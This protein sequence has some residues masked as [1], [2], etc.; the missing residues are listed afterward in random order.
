MTDRVGA[1][2][3]SEPALSARG[4]FA[5]RLRTHRVEIE[6]AAI[7]RICA[8]SRPDPTDHA[9]AKS[10]AAAVQAMVDFAIDTLAHPDLKMPSRPAS[11]LAH[12]RLSARGGMPLK[13]LLRQH[14]AAQA[15]IAEYVLK[16][17]ESDGRLRGE[18]LRRALRSQ[19][20]AFDC[21]AES[22]GDEY[23]REPQKYLEP[24]E[25]RLAG[26][27]DSILDGQP[28]ASTSLGY[29]LSAHHVAVI[30][31]GPDPRTYL[32][33]LATDRNRS[34][35]LVARPD[36]TVWAWLGSRDI[37][38]VA[39][40]V[41]TLTL[42]RCGQ[43]SIAVGEM[44]SGVSGW[45]MTHR[46]ARAAVRV[47]VR[48]AKQVVRYA[49]VALLAAVLENDL[50]TTSLHTLYLTP[51]KSERDGG[52]RLKNTLRAYLASNCNVASAAAALNVNRNTV[53]NRLRIIERRIG[54]PVTSCISDLDLALQ[55]EELD[56]R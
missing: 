26:V 45:R 24:S 1:G 40:I 28:V 41:R 55:Y 39:E 7:A 29:D 56:P 15:S 16:E 49:D 48:S 8:I 36:G 50:L 3:S 10:L 35:I 9:Y 13:T 18:A 17:A 38:D 25:R 44:G 6:Q 33:H 47:T 43:E 52:E 34:L 14:F 23:Y 12:A 53:A 27:I 31:T 21:L 5:A 22:V 42:A 54:R 20:F 30:A 11:V 32:Q 19:T 4:D 2:S 46:Q 51:L 37:M